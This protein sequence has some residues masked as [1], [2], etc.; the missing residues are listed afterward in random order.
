MMYFRRPLSVQSRYTGMTLIE[1]L[2]TLTIVG[3]ASIIALPALSEYTIKTRTDAEVIELQRFIM[4]A[5]NSAINSGKSVTLC[6]LTAGSCT[7]SWQKELSIFINETDNNKYD[8]A[9]ET[10]VKVKSVISTGDKIKFSDGAT[11]I[12]SPT[13]R[14]TS[15]A[16]V[17]FT[18]CPDGHSSLARGVTISLSGRAYITQDIDDDG[19]DEDRSGSELNCG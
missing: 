16:N 2:I 17:T 15:G 10:L 9:N 11:L 7:T 13:G 5:R 3:I 8:S 14:L 12:Y 4:T 18:Y 6:P 1:I 19:K